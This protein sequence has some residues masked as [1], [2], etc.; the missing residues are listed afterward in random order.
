MMMATGVSS[1]E[2]LRN[3]GMGLFRRARAAGESSRRV[4]DIAECSFG[5]DQRGARLPGS[6]DPLS[7]SRT[8]GVGGVTADAARPRCVTGL[9]SFI[10]AVVDAGEAPWPNESRPTHP[11]PRWRLLKWPGK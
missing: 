8:P 11:C 3:D 1:T 10:N 4:G 9:T 6:S 7:A 2:S 5:L